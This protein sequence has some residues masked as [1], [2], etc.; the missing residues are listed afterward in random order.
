MVPATWSEAARSTEATGTTIASGRCITRRTD[1]A[2][3]AVDTDA[4]V[5][6][7]A[8]AA[9]VAVDK[10]VT[11]SA[12]VA[13]GLAG[14]ISAVGTIA[15]VG[16]VGMGGHTAGAVAAIGSMVWQVVVPTGYGTPRTAVC[17][18]LAPGAGAWLT[19]GATIPGLAEVPGIAAVAASAVLAT[20]SCEAEL[21]IGAVAPGAG[22]AGISPLT[23]ETA[24]ARCTDTAV[25]GNSAVA[26]V[27]AGA[28]IPTW[29]AVAALEAGAI[30][31]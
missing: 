10:S 9:A 6:S 24:V 31:H 3:P 11:A 12:P 7:G 27:T 26:A 28:P 4:A 25:T 19:P 13:A 14:A 18:V 2:G 23:A 29:T 30:V 5:P 15:A 16:A 21:T 22:C 20:R 8:P 1:V 17:T